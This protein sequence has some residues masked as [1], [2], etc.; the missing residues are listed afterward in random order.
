MKLR[1]TLTVFILTASL[2]LAVFTPALADQYAWLNQK[3]ATRTGPGIEYDEPGTFFINAW[4]NVQVKVISRSENKT[5]A[6]VEFEHKGNL[7]RAYT[8]FKRLDGI[9][10]DQVTEEELIGTGYTETAVT[11]YYGPGTWYMQMEHNV[12]A[13]VY[14]DVLMEENGYVLVDY[15]YQTGETTRSRS[16]I[17]ADRLIGYLSDWTEPVSQPYVSGASSPDGLKSSDIRYGQFWWEEE[18]EW[19]FADVEF[20]D[21]NQVFLHM[22]FYRIADIS[23][24]V[25]LDGGNSGKHG[26][27]VGYFDIDYEN[28]ITGEV[29]FL[30]DGFAI[31][32]NAAYID[33]ITGDAF[34]AFPNTVFVFRERNV[35]SPLPGDP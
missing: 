15:P 34:H 14:C 4:R 6:L 8:G 16:W 10:A 31:D 19:S 3:M 24:I 1:M 12:P 11:A 25:T 13:N 9:R 18:P 27:F 20:L 21:G 28:P 29:W 35:I 22:F 5:W 17:P 30:D 26:S 7:F 33:S 32:M 2:L 23:G